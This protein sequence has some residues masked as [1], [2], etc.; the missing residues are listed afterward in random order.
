MKIL[1]TILIGIG[2]LIALVLIVALFLEKD[3]A[4]SREISINKPKQEVFDYV[5]LLK[6]QDNFSKWASMDPAMEKA[7]SGTDGTVGF[8]SAWD[9]Q[10][11]DIGKGEQEIKKI[12]EGEKIEYELRFIEPFESKDAAYFST[13]AINDSTTLVKWGFDGHMAYPMNTMLL[14]MN[15]EEMIGGDFQTGLIT[16]KGILET[17]S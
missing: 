7:Y 11:E 6:N 4:V 16:L 5:K 17:K 8:V 3:Y 9:S 1:K 14:F 15:F 12:T 10:N 13:T 2:S